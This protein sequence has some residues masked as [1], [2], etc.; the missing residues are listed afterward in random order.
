MNMT[1]LT[2][3]GTE[4]TSL[5]PVYPWWLVLIQGIAALVLGIAF[6]AYP[7]LTLFIIVVFVGAYF[8]VSGIFSIIS[9]AL[10]R[11][12]IGWKVLVGI[13]GIVAGLVIL[14][15]PVYST[16]ILPALL[17]LFIGVWGLIIGGTHLAAA[18]S[19]KDWVMGFIGIF[20]V[21]FGIL[22]IVY[23]LLSVA[24]LPYVLGAFGIVGGIIIMVLAFQLK[25][26]S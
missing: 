13:L 16:I 24:I 25:S 17:I 2:T 15:Y 19:T 7:Y 6:L 10:D 18:F 26:I 1:E 12:N 9:I 23:P 4:K 3:A 21:I 11:T 5:M 14:T 22:L 8:F 20:A